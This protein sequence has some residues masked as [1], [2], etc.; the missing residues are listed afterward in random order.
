MTGVGP[1][2]ALATFCFR[3]LGPDTARPCPVLLRKRRHAPRCQTPTWPPPTLTHGRPRPC[4]SQ[5]RRRHGDGLPG[6]CWVGRASTAGQDGVGTLHPAN[7]PDGP[8]LCHR[9]PQ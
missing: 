7:P 4:I 1:V 3:T 2:G 8:E 9:P 5:T 6:L